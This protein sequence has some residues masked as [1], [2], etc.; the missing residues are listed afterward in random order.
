MYSVVLVSGIYIYTHIYPL[1]FRLFSHIGHYFRKHNETSPQK[2]KCAFTHFAYN[3]RGFVGP[4]KLMD[5]YVKE[6]VH[7]GDLC[8]TS[9]HE[10]WKPREGKGQTLSDPASWK[11]HHT[12]VYPFCG[13]LVTEFP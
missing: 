7:S 11:Q 6:L 9:S 13:S 8:T 10:H 3:F 5:N 2:D 12:Q 4:L 1:F